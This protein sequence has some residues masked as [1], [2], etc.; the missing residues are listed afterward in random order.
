MDTIT[1]ALRLLQ[2]QAMIQHQVRRTRG[3]HVMQERELLWIRNRL[4]HF[5]AAV[6]AIAL[7]ASELH[8]TVDALSVRDVE[9]LC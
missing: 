6:Q 9:R 4:A 5:P 7:A 1:E 2:R 3:S 8:R